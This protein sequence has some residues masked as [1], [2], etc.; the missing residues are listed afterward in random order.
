M[1]TITISIPLLDLLKLLNGVKGRKAYVEEISNCATLD[2]LKLTKAYKEGRLGNIINDTAPENM[3]APD[4][5]FITELGYSLWFK[6]STGECPKQ[7]NQFH[8]P[9]SNYTQSGASYPTM[10]NP[11]FKASSHMK[12]TKSWPSGYTR[13]A[14]IYS[15]DSNANPEIVLDSEN[16]SYR[17]NRNAAYERYLGIGL[18]GIG[19]KT[20]GTI[21][22]YNTSYDTS[23]NGSFL[24][25]DTNS[26][27][28]EKSTNSYTNGIDSRIG[29]PYAYPYIIFI[30][31]VLLTVQ[32][33]WYNG[34]G[35]PF[36]EN[37]WITFNSNAWIFE[38]EAEAREYLLTGDYSKALNYSLPPV[39]KKEFDFYYR[40]RYGAE[41]PWPEEPTPGPDVPGEPIIAGTLA[42]AGWKGSGS[43]NLEPSNNSKVVDTV[44]YNGL[45]PGLTYTVV[46][47]LYDKNIGDLI[48]E[49]YTELDFVPEDVYGD[50]YVEINF[51]SSELAGHKLVVF[52]SLYL[53]GVLLS[54]YEDE[55]DTDETVYIL[56][57]SDQD[58][59]SPDDNEEQS[60]FCA[61]DE[62]FNAIGII[63]NYESLIWTDRFDRAG[64]F[65]LYTAANIELF[66]LLKVDNYFYIPQSDKHM[67]VE[68]ISVA[69]DVEDGDKLNITGRSLESI[70][71]RRIVYKKTVINGNLQQG[72]KKIFEDNIINPPIGERRIAN[73]IFKESTD[74]KITKLTLDAEYFGDNIY[75]LVSNVCQT[76]HI[77]FRIRLN[78]SN[79]FVFELYS[80]EDRS[81]DNPNNNTY[82]IFGPEY[83]NVNN[84][85]Y[86]ENKEDYKNVALAGTNSDDTSAWTT[87]HKSYSGLSRRETYISATDIDK[88]NMTT[89]QYKDALSNKGKEALKDY[90]N[91]K[92][93]DGTM[94]NSNLAYLTDFNLGD[95]IEFKDIYGHEVKSRISEIIINHD[96]TGFRIY[97]SFEEIKE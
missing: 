5:P 50:T 79:Q 72:L 62:N 69:S 10:A 31:N 22:R 29:S 80:G 33:N 84:C 74:S 76:N 18:F 82:I 1:A 66:N 44:T 39:P 47:M 4:N 32:S 7:I 73:F 17:I 12:S 89:D 24:D 86:S 64:D 14:L 23:T 81:Y 3:G 13:H 26:S 58:E 93:F 61:V 34:T 6:G 25:S 60:Y 67:I 90:Q 42:H 75:D 41:F 38:T 52:E 83:D 37:S 57:P 95:I 43:H 27:V 63:D 30:A 21:F 96:S 68:K 35:N 77:G 9:T 11:R 91:I 56:N 15:P 40:T 2:E 92:A 51:D 45:I 36:V 71:D 70:I 97:P 53:D 19:L 59:Y 46:G 48:P 28:N 65:E 78:S 94:L 88:D 85:N 16:K 55:E 49:S 54:S 20:D 8:P 87:D